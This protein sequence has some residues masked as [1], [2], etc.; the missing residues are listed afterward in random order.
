MKKLFAIIGVLC[1]ILAGAWVV[2]VGGEEECGDINTNEIRIGFRA[3]T[4]NPIKIENDNDFTNENGV[5]S[6]NGTSENPYIIENWDI[7]G[8]GVGYCIYIGNTTKHFIIRNCTL[9]H[10]TGSSGD[11]LNVYYNEGLAVY[12]A[13]N[14][15]IQENNF[16]SNGYTDIS[17]RNSNNLRIIKNKCSSNSYGNGIY[18]YKS[19]YNTI[20]KNIIDSITERGI[21]I[22]WES[23]YN[24]I[25]NNTCINH[26][27]AGIEVG[28]DCDYCTIENNACTNNR[29]GIELNGGYQIIKN[30]LCRYNQNGIYGRTGIY[31]IK[32]NDCSKNSYNGITVFG[33][34]SNSIIISNNTCNYNDYSGIRFIVGGTSVI[35]NTCFKNR[36]GISVIGSSSLIKNNILEENT[37]YGIELNG[38]DNWGVSNC[39]LYLNT[40]ISNRNQAIDNE[41]DN[42]WNSI[43]Q[44]NYWNDWISPD[45]D[46]N[47]IVDFPYNVSGT[48]GAKDNYPLVKPTKIINGP[49]I[50]FTQDI[51][52]AYVNELYSVKYSAYDPDTPQNELFWT[53]KTNASWL[54]FSRDQ[55]L[56][57]IPSNSNIGSYWVYIAVSDG[58]NSVTT[59]FTVNVIYRTQS[60]VLIVGIE[61][62]F[63]KIQDA[64]DNASDGDT[65]KVYAGTYHEKIVIDKNL[66][67][68]GNSSNKTIING[69]QNERIVLVN[70]NWCNISGFTIKN[71]GQFGLV[72][73]NVDY[74]NL[75]DIIF[76]DNWEGIWLSFVKDF[77]IRNCIFMNN[78]K[79]MDLDHCQNGLITENKFE[80]NSWHAIVLAG[81]YSSN[82]DITIWNNI[83][84]NNNGVTSTYNL[85]NTQVTDNTQIGSN[86]W[87]NSIG[88]GNHWSD[89]T[90]PDNNKDGIV[91][92]PYIINGSAGAKDYYPLVKPSFTPPEP[93]KEGNG[94]V[95]IER[96]GQRFI[97]IQNA[98]DNASAGDIIVVKDGIY[99]E[100]VYVNK[101]LTIKSE[102]GSEKTIVESPDSTSHAFEITADNVIINGFTIR[103]GKYEKIS[104]EP[105]NDR[106]SGIII[107][108]SNHC[109][110]SNNNIYY[111]NSGISLCAIGND[112]NYKTSNYNIVYFNNIFVKNH[113]YGILIAGYWSS[114]WRC[115]DKD[116]SIQ[117]F[118]IGNNI[119]G[120][121]NNKS[122]MGIILGADN[123]IINNNSIESCEIG[124]YVDTSHN[125]SV[126][127]NHIKY[128][129]MGIKLYIASNN[130]IL[131]NFISNN[132]EGIYLRYTDDNYIYLNYFI[133]NINN[134]FTQTDISTLASG[135][136]GWR[137][138]Y[139]K[140]FWNSPDKHKYT[141]NKLEYYNFIGNYWWNWTTPDNNGDGLVDNPYIINEKINAKDYYPLTKMVEIQIDTNIT[142]DF[143]KSKIISTFPEFNSKNVSVNASEIIIKFSTPINTSSVEAAL[144]IS[145]YVN[146]TL[147]WEKNNTVLRIIFNE[148]LY[149]DTTYSITISTDAKDAQG[150]NLNSEFRLDF[151]TEE[152]ESAD[153]KDKPED[154]GLFIVYIAIAIVIIIIFFLIVLA[155]IT[156]SQRKRY[157][158]I[159]KSIE[160]HE[161][162]IATDGFDE[163]IYELKQKASAPYKPSD[164]GLAK[165]EMLAKFEKKYQDG[166]I[167]K[168]TF[169]KIKGSLSDKK[170]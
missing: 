97:K 56:S 58:Y 65:I 115:K 1:I 24:R 61:Q 151:K 157:R 135:V 99:I 109:N 117:N 8:N 38:L 72:I 85:T 22:Y 136:G 149:Y 123:N 62:Q 122:G 116:T 69:D 25:T 140:N 41:S 37:N 82:S 160:K 68:I 66:Y 40:F 124:I 48:A 103:A 6:G 138:F 7:N 96:T 77:T 131:N 108:G 134:A 33:G 95:I 50:L 4:R 166:K 35:N 148:D 53:M 54:T 127:K 55:K 78:V 162:I 36:N 100:S 20:D 44:G 113:G 70:S 74:C 81:G 104:G 43:G 51:H 9:H 161:D 14:G 129:K 114:T 91:D 60:N 76:I 88:Q 139:N 89:W 106:I 57:G 83:F 59:N 128:N 93:K 63:N 164:F 80:N 11:E 169:D 90:A 5:T 107:Q 94:T 87:N 21:K 16:Y 2:P 142:P 39:L 145:P 84:L 12:N 150:N 10:A 132:E 23:S 144:N 170:P 32:N 102:N 146:Y 42:D 156:R 79:G 18:L 167:S 165:S 13:N 120:N 121:T 126:I 73:S 17:L 158:D 105:Y 168:E 143:K 3:N 52:T 137:T 45:S 152:K 28:S 159:E 155:L 15:T 86:Y 119:Y 133:K 30:N 26:T 46:S 153:R 110:I 92:I 163:V 47:G 49:P 141:F 147:V 111:C 101:P 29:E 75:N 27:V 64:I 154:G 130:S 71:A 19:S 118:I 98:I 125:S 34:G 112:Q 31:R 67:V